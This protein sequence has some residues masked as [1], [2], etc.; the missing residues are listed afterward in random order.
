[1]EKPATFLRHRRL[2][3][4]LTLY[5]DGELPR[6]DLAEMQQHLERC[7]AC[8]QKLEDLR[9]CRK[10]L[11]A[12]KTR[13]FVPTDRLW[14]RINGE[15]AAPS[16]EQAARGGRFGPTLWPNLRWVLAAMAVLLLSVGVWKKVSLRPN[17]P[18]AHAQEAIDY[19]VFLSE[20]RQVTTTPNFH[21][22]YS[23]RRVNLA[24]AQQAVAF[25]LA[26]LETLP[27]SFSFEGV[28]VFECNGRKC[29]Q[30]T[31]RKAG[32]TVNLFQHALGQPWTFGSY[33]LARAPICNVE[34]LLVNAKNLAAVSWRG[35]SS[36]FLAVG[37]L[38]PD[39]LEQI[40]HALR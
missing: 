14:Q 8:R 40:V 24:E 17:A 37:E 3:R 34:C 21:K 15:I 26:D 11:H 1:M 7:A 32:K 19:G 28:R 2:Q 35:K 39:E 33:P 12:G 16:P 22:R 10:L 31:Y 27:P 29:I 20:V 13:H 38:T 5:A 6:Q 25:P 30:F 18:A 9:A 23:A 36:E 4:L